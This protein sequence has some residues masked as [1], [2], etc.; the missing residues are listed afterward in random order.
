MPSEN[1]LFENIVQVEGHFQLVCVMDTET[2]YCRVIYQAEQHVNCTLSQH[3]VYYTA[4]YH[5]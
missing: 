1:T 2:D 5:F 4:T 3:S